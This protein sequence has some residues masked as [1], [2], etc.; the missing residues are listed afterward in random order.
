M[1]TWNSLK[2]S[3]C[4]PQKLTRRRTLALAGGAGL[5]ATLN[6]AP[7]ALANEAEVI[8]ARVDLALAR[9][10]REIPGSEALAARASAVLVMPSV[11]KGG[12]IVGG[13]YGE[14]ALRFKD[15]EGA[16]TETVEYY[17]VAAASVGFQAGIQETSHALFFLS[18]EALARFRRTDGWE[19]GADAEVTALDRA[20]NLDLN[21]TV[22]K[23]PVVA[24]VFAGSGLLVGA[25]LEGA[26]YSRIVR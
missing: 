23:R 2:T 26:K 18:E 20:V 22:F 25:S 11:V 13:T 8:D 17:S 24:L 14:G 3:K 7:G 1:A 15:T 5:A 16:Y 4:S 9:L 12:F 21:S 6:P 19:V 10:Y